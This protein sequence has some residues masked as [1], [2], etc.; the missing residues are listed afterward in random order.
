MSTTEWSDAG[1]DI[2][3]LL[4]FRKTLIAL[5]ELCLTNLESDDE[6]KWIDTLV[7][8]HTIKGD[9]GGIFSQ[10]SVL[11]GEKLTKTEVTASN[12]QMVEKKMASDRKSWEHEKLAKEILRRL[13]ETSIDMDTGEVTLTSTEIALKLL[14]YVQ[15]SYWRVKELSKLGVNADQYCEVGEAKT[16]IIVRKA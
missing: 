13:N 14:D 5:S 10:Y 11:I 3:A 7:L 6:Q 15:P 8:L 4:D 9:I 16:S 2:K 12:G 1:S